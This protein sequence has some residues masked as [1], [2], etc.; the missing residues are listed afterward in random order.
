VDTSPTIQMLPARSK[1]NPPKPAVA[2]T[3]GPAILVAATEAGAK[4]NTVDP[5]V[6]RPVAHSL[7][8]VGISA[9]LTWTTVVSP[10]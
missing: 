1:V 5:S 4:P 2:A 6:A 7:P 8:L 10:A 3:S 9:Y